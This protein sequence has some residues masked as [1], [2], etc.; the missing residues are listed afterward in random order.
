MCYTVLSFNHILPTKHS[1]RPGKMNNWKIEQ[2]ELLKLA[3]QLN[4]QNTAIQQL[5]EKCQE[6]CSGH[7]IKSQISKNIEKKIDIED[8]IEEQSVSVKE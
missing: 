8:K 4:K 3:N 2:K 1:M 5:E 7:R 6:Y